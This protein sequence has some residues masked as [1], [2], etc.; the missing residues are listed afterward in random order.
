M[1]QY[2][3]DWTKKAKR[4][5]IIAA[6]I[7]IME[8]FPRPEPTTCPF[9]TSSGTAM[10]LTLLSALAET[11]RVDE[12]LN[13]RAVGGKSCEL[14]IARSGASVLASS[15]PTLQS[16]EPYA[17]SLPF[18]LTSKTV[19]LLVLI[20]LVLIR[21]HDAGVSF[22]VPEVNSHLH[23]YAGRSC[24]FCLPVVLGGVLF[25]IAYNVVGV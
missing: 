2:A 4:S 9:C 13:L 14:R 23:R 16:D 17:R 5:A 18:W 6:N 7:T 19:I 12:G 11:N 3:P 8:I 22:T 25:M 1:V 21:V 10:T 15:T 24:F 20:D